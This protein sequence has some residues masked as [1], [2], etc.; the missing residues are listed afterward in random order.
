MTDRIAEET[1]AW[2]RQHQKD[3]ARVSRYTREQ[4]LTDDY[5][6]ADLVAVKYGVH[7][8]IG[9][10]HPSPGGPRHD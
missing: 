10:H 1:A 8:R 4:L 3:L 2:F 6:Y 7:R 9:S 5:A